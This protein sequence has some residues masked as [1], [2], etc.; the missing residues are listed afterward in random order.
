MVVA[1]AHLHGAYG[2]VDVRLHRVWRVP[3][4]LHAGVN[5]VI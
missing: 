2:S 3:D 5:N 1:M 4:D